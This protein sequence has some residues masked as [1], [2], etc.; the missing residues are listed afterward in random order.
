MYS[1]QKLTTESTSDFTCFQAVFRAQFV[2]KNSLIILNA[3]NTCR[4]LTRYVFW[5]ARR[6]LMRNS[7]VFCCRCLQLA[8]VMS[9]LLP[10]VSVAAHFSSRKVT[11]G[12]ICFLYS[13]EAFTRLLKIQILSTDCTMKP[14]AADFK[15]GDT[16]FVAPIF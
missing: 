2:T 8:N 7:I 11:C 16:V 5:F 13:D 12:T 6:F 9:I 4:I 1:K 14:I 3:F 10:I 15:V